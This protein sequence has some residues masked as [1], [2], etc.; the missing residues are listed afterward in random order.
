MKKSTYSRA[1]R[2]SRR[3]TSEFFGVIRVGRR[4]SV[5]S[6]DRVIPPCEQSSGPHALRVASAATEPDLVEAA[7]YARPIGRPGSRSLV[8]RLRRDRSRAAAQLA[9]HRQPSLRHVPRPALGEGVSCWA[10]LAAG[11]WR[12]LGA[13]CGA[14][15]RHSPARAEPPQVRPAVCP[16]ARPGR[17]TARLSLREAANNSRGAGSSLGSL[18]SEWAASEHPAAMGIEAVPAL[19]RPRVGMA[20]GLF[21]RR[22]I[23]WELSGLP[24]PTRSP[25]RS[26]AGIAAT[27]PSPGLSSAGGTGARPSPGLL[28]CGSPLRSLSRAWDAMAPCSGRLAFPS[29]FCGRVGSP[30]ERDAPTG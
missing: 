17:R 2:P 18:A 5:P 3:S 12:C 15:P 26:S 9:A 7:R 11:V 29:C 30:G 24:R 21:G 20:C 28:V 16:H 10:G 27:S 8:A 13:G 6:A 14:A 4:Y 19:P 22:V 1:A 25:G 23:S